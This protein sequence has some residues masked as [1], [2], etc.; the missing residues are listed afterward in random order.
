MSKY[1]AKKPMMWVTKDDVRITYGGG[2]PKDD[3]IFFCKEIVYGK[4]CEEKMMKK[5]IHNFLSLCFLR[6]DDDVRGWERRA[7]DDIR[8]MCGGEVK[9]LTFQDDDISGHPLIGSIESGWKGFTRKIVHI[10]PGACMRLL[11][12][13]RRSV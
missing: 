10:G 12:G 1:D 6:K 9:K 13:G 7:K 2:C 4:F 3:V 5:K 8:I 11:G